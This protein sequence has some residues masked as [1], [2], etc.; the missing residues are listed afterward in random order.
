M[1][2]PVSSP[3]GSPSPSSRSLSPNYSLSRS[4]S[5]DNSDDFDV[6]FSPNSPVS[7]NILRNLPSSAS[8]EERSPRLVALS[9]AAAAAV[10]EWVANYRF[11]AF[12]ADLDD[13]IPPPSPM[14]PSSPS[15]AERSPVGSPPPAPPGSRSVPLPF[16]VSSQRPSQ[17]PPNALL[18]ALPLAAL[19]RNSGEH[20]GE[21]R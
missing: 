5:S 16:F 3:V 13:E 21:N 1:S 19:N 2:N 20:E 6:P 17:L 18:A 11:Q 8:P 15:S 7:S 10:E 4:V 14:D 9:P 12:F